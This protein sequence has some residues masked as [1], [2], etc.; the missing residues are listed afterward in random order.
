[1][2]SQLVSKIK[3]ITITKLMLKFDTF[4]KVPCLGIV[5]SSRMYGEMANG[6]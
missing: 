5:F 4:L 6:D 2:T 1:M 3:V